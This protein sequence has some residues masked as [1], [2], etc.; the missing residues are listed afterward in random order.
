MNNFLMG[1]MGPESQKPPQNCRNLG[2]LGVCLR[3]PG[4]MV[5][6]LGQSQEI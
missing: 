1:V 4:G 5:T 3:R 2:V 6:I